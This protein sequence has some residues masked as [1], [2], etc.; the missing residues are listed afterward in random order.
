[1]AL[2]WPLGSCAKWSCS[3]LP[4][5]RGFQALLSFSRQILC[6]RLF[7]SALYSSSGR[8]SPSRRTCGVP[9]FLHIQERIFYSTRS[10]FA[11]ILL[12]IAFLILF[13]AEVVRAWLTLL[14]PGALVSG[15]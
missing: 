14:V 10:F 15:A 13:P 2:H 9:R 8:T 7:T 12:R 1:M 11:T 5:S 4:S 3:T 6:F